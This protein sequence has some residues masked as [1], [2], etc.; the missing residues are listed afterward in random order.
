ML[1]AVLSEELGKTKKFEL[2]AV[3]SEQMRIWT[4]RPAWRAE[5]TL[6]ADSWKGAP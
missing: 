3:T 1:E 5:E 2:V 4:G 6:P